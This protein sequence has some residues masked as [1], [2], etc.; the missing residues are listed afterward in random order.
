MTACL[1][2]AQCQEHSLAMQDKP[3]HFS[4]EYGAWFSDALIVA[5]YPTRPPYPESVIQLLN[6][7]CV[8]TPRTV[9]DIGCGPGDLA[10]RLAPLVERVDA[11]DMSAGMIEQGHCL[12]GGD[13]GN[14]CW[15][16]STVEAAT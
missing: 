4:A 14:L 5:A 15:I 1:P 3:S 11:V 6:S 9:L 2:V 16:N 12:P 13:A 7:L 8:D 10:R